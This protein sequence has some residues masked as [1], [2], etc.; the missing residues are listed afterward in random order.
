MHIAT[1]SRNNNQREGRKGKRTSPPLRQ[2]KRRVRRGLNKESAI[3]TKK[4]THRVD[5][6]SRDIQVLTR[7]HLG[8]LHRERIHIHN[9]QPARKRLVERIERHAERAQPVH[10]RAQCLGLVCQLRERRLEEPEAVWRV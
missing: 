10:I 2:Y 1:R 8:P 4:N 3:V 6:K 9:V 7:T 5:L